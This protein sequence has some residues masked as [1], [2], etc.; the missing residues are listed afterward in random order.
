MKQK[1]FLQK[2]LPQF[3]HSLICC[4]KCVLLQDGFFIN[5]YQFLIKKIFLRKFE[6]S[7]HRQ[8]LEK[9]RQKQM[10]QGINRILAH[11]GSGAKN[12]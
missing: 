10:Y 11:A 9:E 2:I 5:F 7:P 4:V 3:V 12:R 1:K 6:E 8:K